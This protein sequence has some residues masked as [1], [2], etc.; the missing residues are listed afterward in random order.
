VIPGFPVFVPGDFFRDYAEKVNLIGFSF[1]TEILNA[2]V[3]GEISYRP[4]DPIPIDANDQSI[5]QWG[6]TASPFGRPTR[7]GGFVTEEKI[8]A[9]LSTIQTFGPSTRWGIGHFVELIAADTITLTT[10]FALV[11][12][13]NLPHECHSPSFD[14][15]NAVFAG[16]GCVPLV[17]PGGE[18]VDKTS[19]GYQMLMLIDYT[20]PLDIPIT[21][22]PSVGWAHAI[23]GNSPYGGP[24]V[25]EQKALTVGV[26]VDYLE[27]WGGKVTYG[28]FM[29][30]GDA[31]PIND[32]D[33]FSFSVSYAF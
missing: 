16:G 4:D 13:P 20:N 9:Q 11:N 30:A 22:T 29:G 24:F 17:G 32:R 23:G 3:S 1:A 21:L 18:K 2:N 10:E 31:N 12:Y 27:T 6:S 33:F 28:R 19:Y 7:T 25:E 15:V 8:Q 26:E 14:F 5:I